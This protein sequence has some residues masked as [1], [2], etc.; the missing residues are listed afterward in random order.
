MELRILKKL[1]LFIYCELK[2]L[3]MTLENLFKTELKGRRLWA[4]G[5][6]FILFLLVSS[7]YC[8]QPNII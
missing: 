4:A 5:A 3:L 6:I 8:F 1:V 2:V 7:L